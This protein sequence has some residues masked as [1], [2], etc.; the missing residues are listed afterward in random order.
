MQAYLQNEEA[1]EQRSH[2]D[3]GVELFYHN[4]VLYQWQH[5]H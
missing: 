4:N 3:I 5:R 1:Q 2:F